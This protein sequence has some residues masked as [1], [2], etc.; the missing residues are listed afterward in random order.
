M[1]TKA[2]LGQL[3]DDDR[4]TAIGLLVEAYGLLSAKL[5]VEM[6]AEGEV[7]LTWYGVLVRLGRSPDQRMRMSD[8]AAAVSLT[9][10]GTTRLVDRIEAAG[11]IE[12]QPCPS[13]RR[14]SYVSLT[15]AGRKALA[16]A[17]PV[18]VRGIQ[19]HLL[20]VLSPEEYDAFVATLRKLR[21]E[22]QR[23]CPTPLAS[24]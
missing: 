15:D 9:S 3:L 11:L 7:P 2:A 12:R 16:K 8:L 19:Q 14:V 22:H 6:E 23:A 1:P 18:H 4:I 10:S 5:G 24:E 17:T 21:D 20:D 13:D